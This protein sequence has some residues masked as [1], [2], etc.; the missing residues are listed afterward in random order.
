MR[1]GIEPGMVC[2]EYHADEGYWSYKE[3][4]PG[5]ERFYSEPIHPE[6]RQR[7]W[8]DWPDDFDYGELMYRKDLDDLH[9]SRRN[10]NARS[11]S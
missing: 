9:R 8:T 11:A 4:V 10:M 6:N 5:S 7:W 2:D 1:F 3:L